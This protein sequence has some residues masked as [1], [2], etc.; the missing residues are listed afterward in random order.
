MVDPAGRRVAEAGYTE[1]TLLVDLDLELVDKV[2]KT[3]PVL[4]GLAEAATTT[5]RS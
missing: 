2:R 1:E 3:L 4:D 5:P